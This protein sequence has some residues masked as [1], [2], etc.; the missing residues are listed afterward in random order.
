MTFTAIFGG[1]F[2]P[3]HKGHYDIL[4][5]LCK[6]NNIEKVLVLPDRIPPHKVCNFLAPDLDRIEMC[7][8]ACND[9]QKAELCLIEFEREG[10]SYT[11]DTVTLLK[12]MYPD[13]EF[14]VVVG[15]DMLA[16]L[17]TWYNFENLKK[18]VSFLAFNRDG[19]KEF[20]NNL[21]RIRAMGAD[22]TVMED[23]ITPV[24]ST[25]LREKIKAENIPPKIY[26]YI[27]EKGLYNA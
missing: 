16:S 15:A 8:I 11:Y 9:F 4:A 7:R 22:V 21:N 24:S 20:L 23:I 14:A 1:T 3:F 2:N 10:K 5:S 13:T 17:D 26:D 6:N 19:S 12:K 18:S 25:Q 27:K